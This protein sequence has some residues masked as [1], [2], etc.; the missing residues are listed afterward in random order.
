H[1]RVLGLGWRPLLVG[2]SDWSLDHDRDRSGQF[3]RHARRVSRDGRTLPHRAVRAK[4]AGADG[5]ALRLAYKFLR[6]ANGGCASLRAILEEVSS[7]SPAVDH[8]EQRQTR[9]VG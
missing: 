4:S 8:G 1:V 6:Y 9:D 2:I 7:L 5:I 3:P